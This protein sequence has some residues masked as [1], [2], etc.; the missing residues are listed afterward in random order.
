M[1]N[2]GLLY[3]ECMPPNNSTD[4]KSV[5]FY[6]ILDRHNLTLAHENIKNTQV[7]L[8]VLKKN[9]SVH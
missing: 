2:L 8:S 1:A 4:Y 3:T 5:T 9:L 6:T 7:L